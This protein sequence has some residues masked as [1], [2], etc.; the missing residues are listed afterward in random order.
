MRMSEERRQRVYDAI[1][2]PIMKKRIYAEVHGK[3]GEEDLYN[4]DTEIW[5]GV[6]KIL[7]LNGGGKNDER[8]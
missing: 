7:G 6:K 8:E 4:L 5:R 1:A 2:E 3:L